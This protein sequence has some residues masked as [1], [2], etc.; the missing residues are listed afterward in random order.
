M[1]IDQTTLDAVLGLL[2]EVLLTRDRP[3]QH[4]V[5]CGGSS[6]SPRLRISFISR[7][8]QIFLK[9]HATADRDASSKHYQDLLAL[10]PTRDELLA[11]ARWIRL[12]DPSDGF[13]LVL[14]SVLE[15]LGH[16]DLIHQIN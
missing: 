4:F 12:H 16:G 6:L 13:R 3:A 10:A 2:G 11:A 5:V 7:Y 9:L 14:G 8:D 1:K 15:H